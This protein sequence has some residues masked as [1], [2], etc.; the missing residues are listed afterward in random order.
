VKCNSTNGAYYT[1]VKIHS[2]LSTFAQ[3]LLRFG[4]Y[5]ADRRSGW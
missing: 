1:V 3:S 2:T 5:N 4:M